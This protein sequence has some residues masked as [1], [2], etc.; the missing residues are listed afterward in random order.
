M[1]FGDLVDLSFLI[2]V[3]QMRKNP[4]KTLHW[5]LVPSGDR[6]LARCVTGS[7]STASLQ[8]WTNT[9]FFL[10]NLTEKEAFSADYWKKNYARE[11]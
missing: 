11:S 3:L 8:W 5:K 10:V 7:H 2:F 6:T 4:E 9:L 1:I